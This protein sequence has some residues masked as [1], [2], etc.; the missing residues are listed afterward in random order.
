MQMKK[1]FALLFAIATPL[2]VH[3]AEIIQ[4]EDFYLYKKTIL[5]ITAEWKDLGDIIRETDA[6]LKSTNTLKRAEIEVFILPKLFGMQDRLQSRPPSHPALQDMNAHLMSSLKLQQE[7]WFSLTKIFTAST[8][9]APL[10]REA[11]YKQALNL[12]KRSAEEY[13]IFK[14]GFDATEMYFKK[15]ADG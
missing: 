11:S 13:Q 15:L 1:V 5:S 10:I 8:A 2:S 7:A 14:K 12:N 3:G 6:K 9:D 4:P